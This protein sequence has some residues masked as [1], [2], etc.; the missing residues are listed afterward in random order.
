MLLVERIQAGDERAHLGNQRRDVVFPELGHRRRIVGGGRFEEECRRL[1][2]FRRE[3]DALAHQVEH[4]A[5]IVVAEGGDARAFRRPEIG[6]Q[7]RRRPHPQVFL[8]EPFGLVGIETGTR[9]DHALQREHLHQLVE[10]EDLLLR[11]GI[12]AQESQHVDEGLGIIA[13]LAVAP[14]DLALGVDPAQREH[15]E[16]EP[17]AIPFRKFALAVRLEQQ[18]QVREARLRILPAE[19]LVQ[20]IVQGQGRE[21]LLAAD[22]FGDF[23]QV[24]VH[25]IGQ[26]VGRQFVGTFPQHLVVEGVAVDFDVAADQVVHGHGPVLRN[27]EADGPVAGLGQA[28]GH[29]VGGEG[30]RVAE[31]APRLPVVGEGL[32]LRFRFGA[33]GGEAFG[34]VEGIIGIAFLDKLFRVFAVDAAALRLAVRRVGM[35]LRRDFHH[36][37]VLIHALVGEDAAPAEALDD[38]FFR[39]RHETLGVGVLDAEDEIAAGLFGVQIIIE[40][41]ADTA[42]VE[43]PGRARCKTYSASSFH[44]FKLRLQGFPWC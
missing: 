7:L 39:A 35:P 12:P 20:Q 32:L 14:R 25:D 6:H 17:V 23:H 11:A 30:Q 15:R 40:R 21:P 42:H 37:A 31:R 2:E 19:G 1:A 10:R 8:V 22:D 36:L 13:V 26:V 43:R 38:V 28:A 29:L 3:V 41:R 9:F 24:V 16:T 34:A 4:A 44:E 5:H 27:L 33:Q 18:R